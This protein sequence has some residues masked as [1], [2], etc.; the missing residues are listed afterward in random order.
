LWEV[1]VVRKIVVVQ[2]VGIVVV[3]DVLVDLVSVVGTKPVFM[4]HS[5]TGLVAVK[6]RLLFGM[7][8]WSLYPSLPDRSRLARSYKWIGRASLYCVEPL[9]VL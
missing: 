6:L 2:I 9:L 5:G 8:W 3:L 7:G 1:V 4:R